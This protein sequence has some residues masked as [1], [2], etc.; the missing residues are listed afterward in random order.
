MALLREIEGAEGRRTVVTTASGPARLSLGLLVPRACPRLAVLVFIPPD[1]FADHPDFRETPNAH[2]D[3]FLCC[4][5]LELDLQELFAV[6][7]V[8]SHLA[9]DVVGFYVAE[10]LP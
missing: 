1:H 10:E 2:P 9:R 5:V 3:P 6:P 7:L 4:E 8:A